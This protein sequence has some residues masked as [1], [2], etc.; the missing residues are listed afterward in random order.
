MTDDRRKT[1]TDL[2][3][4]DWGEPDYPSYLVTSVYALRKKP[5]D[6]LTVEELRLAIGENVGTRYLVP[7]ALERLSNDPLAEGHLYRGDLFRSVIG[8]AVPFW[9]ENAELW[10]MTQEVAESF[11]ALVG[12]EQ[13]WYP[14]LEREIREEYE[15][16]LAAQPKLNREGRKSVTEEGRS[17]GLKG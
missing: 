6:D 7:L 15:L 17:E 12:Q 8:L 10:E 3:R 11:W 1:L 9:E 4:D 2:E 16:F 5:L 14:S 13:P